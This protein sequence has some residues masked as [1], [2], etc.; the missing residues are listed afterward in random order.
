MLKPREE[1]WGKGTRAAGPQEGRVGG[2][3]KNLDWK[4]MGLIRF[5]NRRT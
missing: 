1:T 5:E 4:S 2:W 3:P